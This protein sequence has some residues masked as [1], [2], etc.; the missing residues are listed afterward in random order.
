MFKEDYYK[1]LTD[2]YVAKAFQIL[3]EKEE[4]VRS[5]LKEANRLVNGPE[6][7]I[8]GIRRIE[9]TSNAFSNISCVTIQ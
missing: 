9:K 2:C 7:T 6:E 8:N 5:D 4:K 1:I 3:E